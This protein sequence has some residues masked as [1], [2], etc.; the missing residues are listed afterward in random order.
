MKLRPKANNFQLWS[1]LCAG[2]GNDVFCI[3]RD[4]KRMVELYQIDKKD[5]KSPTYYVLWDKRENTQ[6]SYTNYLDAI[7]ALRCNG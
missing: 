6:K 5:K 2:L 4:Q 3:E 1:K 7:S